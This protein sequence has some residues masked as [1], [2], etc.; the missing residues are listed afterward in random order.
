MVLRGFVAE[1]FALEVAQHVAHVGDL[2]AYRL[3]WQVENRL[4][5]RLDR[6]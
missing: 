6:C 5:R 4:E 2:G 1:D 3:R